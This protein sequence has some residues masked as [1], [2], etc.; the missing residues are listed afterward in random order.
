MSCLQYIL[1]I[2]S[3]LRHQHTRW[4][5][6]FCFVAVLARFK[7]WKTW[8]TS[9]YFPRSARFVLVVILTGLLSTFSTKKTVVTYPI[10][11][12]HDGLL[13]QFIHSFIHSFHPSFLPF[14]SLTFSCS[15]LLCS[16]D[17]SVVNDSS[18]FGLAR[19]IEFALSVI[20]GERMGVVEVNEMG[21]I[22]QKSAM[23]HEPAKNEETKQYLKLPVIFFRS[24]MFLRTRC[25]T[26]V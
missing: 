23:S 2:N 15:G 10:K 7:K 3:K 11:G 6:E 22:G 18:R 12:A 19:K 17:G 26:L 16:L 25:E 1:E 13:I 20:R 14:F 8:L 24:S 21:L 5:G 4:S 9:P